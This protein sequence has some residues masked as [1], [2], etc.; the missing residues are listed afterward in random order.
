[1]IILHSS[2]FEQFI[3]H[4]YRSYPRDHEK[5]YQVFST[6]MLLGFSNAIALQYTGNQVDV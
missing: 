4:H 3:L 6:V 1:M 2:V 5:A